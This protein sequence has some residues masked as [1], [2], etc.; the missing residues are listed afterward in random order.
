MGNLSNNI[1]ITLAFAVI[2]IVWGTTFLAIRFALE[3]IP[4]FMM[5]GLRF[6]VAG[7]LLFAWVYFRNPVKIKLRHLKLPAITGLL[8]IFIGHGSLA[9]AEQ[10]ISSGFAALLCSVIPVWMVVLSWV[11]SRT[12]KPDKLTVAGIILGITG[13]ALLTVTGNQFSISTTIGSGMII[14]NILPLLL[15][16]IIWSYASIKSREFS[17]ELPLLY[18]VS[19]QILSGGT[20]LLLLGIFRGEAAELSAT[21][22]S[23]I[24]IASMVYLVFFGTIVAYSS[25]VWLLK[26]STPAKV[27]TY[28]FFNPLIAVFLGWLIID[29]PVT[30]VMIIG[31]AGILVSVLLINKPFQNK[32]LPKIFIPK[33]K[34][35]QPEPRGICCEEAA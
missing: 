21:S 16:G 25:Y 27:G 30:T 13:V 31:A 10:F 24:S 11:Q 17:K 35:L 32:K 23:F 20:A 28:A 4:P 18:S 15:S 14:F 34:T 1:K 29:E 26:A 8:M 2:Y 12:N 9:W 5:A 7:V 6:T 33:K 19:V 22:I 3:T